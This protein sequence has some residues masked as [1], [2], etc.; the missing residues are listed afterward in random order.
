MAEIPLVKRGEVGY[1]D[2]R[3]RTAVKSTPAL[4]REVVTLNERCDN[5]TI[6]KEWFGMRV[7]VIAFPV[8][9]DAEGVAPSPRKP[10]RVNREWL[11]SMRVKPNA[12]TA[13]ELIRSDRDSRG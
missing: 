7:E 4:F 13:D 1:N 12:T 10:F 2:D 8:P 6:P 5:F 9:M 11:A 3:M